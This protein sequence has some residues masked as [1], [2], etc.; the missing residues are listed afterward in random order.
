M[1]SIT[2]KDTYNPQNMPSFGDHSTMSGFPKDIMM[3]LAILVSL[4]VLKMVKEG[5]E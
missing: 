4:W 5:H 2:M 1:G 3:F